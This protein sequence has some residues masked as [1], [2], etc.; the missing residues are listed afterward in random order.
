MRM[1]R[2]VKIRQ[3]T[4]GEESYETPESSVALNSFFGKVSSGFKQ[5][6]ETSPYSRKNY[7]SPA[8][9]DSRDDTE[10]SNSAISAS[11]SLRGTENLL[12][13]RSKERNLLHQAYK[14]LWGKGKGSKPSIQVALIKGSAGVGKT[15]LASYMKESVIKDG[16]YFV[17]GKFDQMQSAELYC[18]FVSAFTDMIDQVVQRGPGSVDLMKT[19]IKNAVHIEQRILVDMIPSLEAILGFQKK[20]SFNESR[21]SS[22]ELNRFKFVFRMFVRAIS[23]LERPLVMLL[24]DLHFAD[25]SSLDLL[26]AIISDSNNNGVL[27]ICTYRD[28]RINNEK[29]RH[30]FNLDGR[31]TNV[32]EI[33]LDNLPFQSFNQMM[34]DTFA[35]ADLKQIQPLTDLIYHRTQG[36]AFY[37][38]E[39]LRYLQQEGLLVFDERNMEW[40]WDE[41]KIL[42]RMDFRSP[43]ELVTTRLSALPK[44]TREVLEVAACLG[45]RIDEKLLNRISPRPVYGQLQRAVSNGFLILENTQNIY[46]F[47]HDIVQEA[48]YKLVA[49]REREAFHLSIGRELWKS[50]DQIEDLERHI[51]T[52]LGQIREGADLITH[53]SERNDVAALCLRAGELAMESSSFQTAS[54][55]LLFGISL[56]GE[57]CWDEEY[58]LSLELFNASLQVENSISNFDN[59]ERLASE[60]YRRSKSFPDAFRAH[61]IHVSSLGSR[62]HLHKAIERG[63]S[64]LSAL[65]EKFP[66]KISSATVAAAVTKTKKLL[67]ARSN[68]DILK[69][70]VASNGTK[71]AAMQMMNH[72]F[73]YA[74]VAAPGLA[75][76]LSARMVKLSLEHGRCDASSIGFVTFALLLCRDVNEINEGFR[77]GELALQLYRQF[78]EKAWL[79]RFSAW[80]YG[81]VY[82]WKKPVRSIFDPLKSA[83]RVALESGDID[84]AVLNANFYCWESFDISS[85]AKLE[86][87]AAGFA[88]RVEAY[89]QDSIIMMI[90]PA[91][92]MAHNMMGKAYGDPTI[93]TGEIMNQEH[94]IQYARENNKGLLIWIH[95]YRMFI[96]YLL[97]DFESAEIHAGVCRIAEN[98]PFGT[99]D[100]VL[101]VFYD[102]LIAL[103]QHRRNRNRI[104]IAKR[105][106]QFLK[107]WA[108]N[109]PENYLGKLYLLE[110]EMAVH[111]KDFDRAH[112]KYTSAISL[113]REGGY[114]VQNAIA[115]E[116]TGKFFLKQGNLITARSYL[117]EAVQ[118]YGKWGGTTKIQ[119]LKREMNGVVSGIFKGEF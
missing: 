109:C 101:F 21:R 40:I 44:G 78:D 64:V 26:S 3:R 76:L 81:G 18:A 111:S 95:F 117:K 53:P 84:Y 1:R 55:Y 103:A 10:Y 15:I 39:L 23:S 90:K 97:G 94:A 100:R 29:I 68:E 61:T 36:N 48:A 113:S 91:W 22:D 107:T 66:C 63:L 47:A 50:F 87:I 9:S 28:D 33:S 77:Y 12:Y 13:G 104:P 6:K 71:I 27:F 8:L 30:Y 25:E 112:S 31:R 98:N 79:G 54:E 34:A 35:V 67:R 85:L 17:R 43:V 74:Y 82:L 58:E 75:P 102:G 2:Q 96:A 5:K 4:Y 49:H 110:A 105:S 20:E 70:P 57:S 14:Q 92:Q 56:L 62:G 119:Q 88:N 59:V 51:Y 89:G 7:F 32:T 46:V 118:V 52:I 115:N 83:H 41:R 116:R 86:R 108:K 60:I 80:F 69:I 114:I 19:S 24:D 106:I 45:S 72:L 99:S 16:G 11:S 73:L 65:G 38:K 93:L 42:S 37:V